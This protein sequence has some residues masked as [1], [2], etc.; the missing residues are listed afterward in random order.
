MKYSI[1][2]SCPCGSKEKYKKCCQ[3]FHKGK[4]PKTAL[5]LMKS[6]YSAYVFS[7]PSYIIKTTHQENQD[8]MV[9]SE[10]WK[11]DIFNFCKNTSFVNLKVLEFI[12][13]EDEAFVTFEATLFSDNNDI[14]FTEKSRFLKPNTMWLYHS[15]EFIL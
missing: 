8:F 3:V 13:G 4:Y 11:K 12:D 14:S 6:R 5:E 15:G 1:N 9:D 2:S 10:S 7:L